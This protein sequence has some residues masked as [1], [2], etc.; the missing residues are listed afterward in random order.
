MNSNVNP[1]TGIRYGII[2]AALLKPEIVE[3]VRSN[4]ENLSY[5]D[6][7]AEIRKDVDAM[8]EAEQ[9]D[10]DDADDEIARRIERWSD[11]VEDEVFY[12]EAQI[13][14]GKLR[15]QTTTLGAAEL[16]WVFESPRTVHARLCSP[17][18]PNC[19]DLSEVFPEEDGGL[20]PH[21]YFLCYDVPQGWRREP[22]PK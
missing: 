16:L 8:V 11:C 15:V 5:A 2:Q 12:Y 17:C 22:T 10:A 6:A 9:L 19:G 3:R 4:G 20:A 14:G 13:E 1:E 7:M 21:D 18:V